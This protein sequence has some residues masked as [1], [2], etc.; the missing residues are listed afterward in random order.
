MPLVALQRAIEAAW[1]GQAFLTSECSL[2]H[3]DVPGIIKAY[4]AHR[5]ELKR[6]QMA[7]PHLPCL[8]AHGFRCNE[9]EWLAAITQVVVEHMWTCSIGL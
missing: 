5:P 8:K 9:S 7:G 1:S 6:E 2:A 3:H 4:L